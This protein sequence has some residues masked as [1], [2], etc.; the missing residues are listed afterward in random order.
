MTYVHVFMYVQC[1]FSI[2]INLTCEIIIIL[3]INMNKLKAYA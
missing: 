3:L 1:W 2:F